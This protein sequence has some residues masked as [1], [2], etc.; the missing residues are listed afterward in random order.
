MERLRGEDRFARPDPEHDAY[1]RELGCRLRSRAR[2]A[3]DRAA[4]GIRAVRGRGAELAARGRES[5]PF[6]K[7][8]YGRGCF[9]R[10]AGCASC[11]AARRPNEAP[12]GSFDA[13]RQRVPR[14]DRGSR[15]RARATRARVL[16][17]AER[18]ARRRSLLRRIA[19]PL[20]IVLAI[21]L[22]GAALTAAGHPLARARRRPRSPTRDGGAA[23]HRPRGATPTRTVPV[24]ARRI[25]S[26]ADTGDRAA[27][28]RLAYERA[29]RAHFFA[30]RARRRAGRLGR[31]TSPPI[32][33]GT[34]APE[35][36][37]NRALCLVRLRGSPPRPR[38]LRP[39]ATGRFGGYR[40][41]EACLLLRWLAERD[42]RVA[43]RAAP[44]PPATESRARRRC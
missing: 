2:S 9:T 16:A 5:R 31:S 24:L 22:S 13:T 4:R 18:E 39:F 40:R 36:R 17:R 14:H 27:G 42:A 29:H 7:R 35:A 30:R 23:G 28:E 19:A 44:A 10:G 15:R 8:R 41:H 33:R 43:P 1:R 38:A 34:F 21:L 26:L 11:S 3:A 6:R 25:P 37:Y 12:A 32:P 20:A